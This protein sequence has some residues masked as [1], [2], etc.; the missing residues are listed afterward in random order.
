MASQDSDGEVALSEKFAHL[1]QPIRDL[2]ENWTINV[3]SALEDYLDELEG[4]QITLGDDL[5]NV[6]TGSV[7][8][9]A[10]EDVESVNFA[11][12]ALLIQV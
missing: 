5:R 1:L 7:A 11:Q 2:A 10:S 8:S 12:A 4:I 9:E 3:A 6:V